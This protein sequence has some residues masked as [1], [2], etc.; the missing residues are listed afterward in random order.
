[1]SRF[2]AE[3]LGEL[4]DFGLDEAIALTAG[5][6]A[7]VFFYEEAAQLFT[8]HAWSNQAMRVSRI[9]EPTTLHELDKNGLWAE[10]VRRREP[11]VVNDFA[12]PGASKS[13][14]NFVSVFAL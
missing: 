13:T 6:M 5:Q 9:T 8:P 14:R 12:D 2:R 4:L 10:S 11:V 1:M 3:S 7:Y